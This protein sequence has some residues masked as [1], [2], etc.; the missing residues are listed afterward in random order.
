MVLSG[1]ALRRILGASQKMD[2]VFKSLL[3]ACSRGGLRGDTTLE[4]GLW[5]QKG[6][7][8]NVYTFHQVICIVH[9]ETISTQ[10]PPSR[11][12]ELKWNVNGFYTPLTGR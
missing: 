4:S 10:F 1:L 9:G 5:E 11:I 8:P 6:G 7:L 3:Q 2:V 12:M